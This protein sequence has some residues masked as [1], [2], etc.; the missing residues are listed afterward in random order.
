[1][2]NSY[3][4][5]STLFSIQSLHKNIYIYLYIQ[6]S[7]ISDRGGWVVNLHSRCF[8]ILTKFQKLHIYIFTECI[9]LAQNN[10]SITKFILSLFGYSVGGLRKE[11]GVIVK[12]S[13]FYNEKKFW[14][15]YTLRIN[16]EVKE[17]ITIKKIIFLFSCF[18]SQCFFQT[19]NRNING[20][21]DV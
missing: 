12:R 21:G 6:E 9:I 20:D 13:F 10:P 16:N 14:P 8:L 3:L 7:I 15:M 5:G 17:K 19:T 2:Y 1:M 18:I 11:E 4:Q